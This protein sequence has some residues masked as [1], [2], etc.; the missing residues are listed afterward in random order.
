VLTDEQAYEEYR[1][2]ILNLATAAYRRAKAQGKRIPLEDIVQTGWLGFFHGKRKWDPGKG[3]NLCT[4]CALF[5]RGHIS[6]MV[7]GSARTWQKHFEDSGVNPSD[8]FFSGLVEKEGGGEALS[9]YLADKPEHVSD[10]VEMAVFNGFKASKIARLQGMLIGDVLQILGD[11]I[12]WF[13][14]FE[15]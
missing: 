2:L 3:S 1:G 4:Y 10:V 5:A 11:A 9:S 8:E 14:V 7:W 6:R 13:I 12:A 15:N